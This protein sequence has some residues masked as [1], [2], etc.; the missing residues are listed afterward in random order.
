MHNPSLGKWLVVKIYSNYGY[1][2][3]TCTISHIIHTWTHSHTLDTLTHKHRQKRSHTNAH[4]NSQTHT[5]SH[6]HTH[7]MCTCTTCIHKHTDLHTHTHS[8]QGR[9][10][11]FPGPC[12]SLETR[13]CGDGAALR[14]LA[15]A[16]E[17]T[18]C[19]AAEAV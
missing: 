12:F 7:R 15:A 8:G 13:Q 3:H 14:G 1:T 6:M 16:A 11:L 9:Q 18:E 2:I 17:G 5:I 4:R 19:M 10:A